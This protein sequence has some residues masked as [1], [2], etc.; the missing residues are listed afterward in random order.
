MF[1]LNESTSSRLLKLE[2]ENQSLQSTIQE[3]REASLSLEE[4]QL[5]ALELERENQ[6]L[7]KKVHHSFFL[8]FFTHFNGIV[9]CNKGFL[10][11]D[12][13]MRL[14][15]FPQLERLQTQLD[16]E[17][18]TTQDMESLG[19]ELLKEKQR[20]EKALQ[21]L[22]AEKDKQVRANLIL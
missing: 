6:G 20:M 4:G 9:I 7:S 8:F 11:S 17:K 15:V 3:L 21:T 12:L 1:E 22:Q 16:Q 14:V 5:H 18:Q 13:V 19:E 2:K 10:Y